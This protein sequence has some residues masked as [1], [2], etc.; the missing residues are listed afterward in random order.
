MNTEAAQVTRTPHWQSP[1]TIPR[2]VTTTPDLRVNVLQLGPSLEVKGGVS[3]VEQ[4]IVDYMAPFASIRHVPTM[5]DGSLIAKSR[6]FAQAITTI[7][8]TLA[9]LEPTVFHI[10]FASRGSTLRKL[11][12]AEMVLRASRPLVMHAHGAKFD[13][14][15]RGLPPPLRRAV[16]RTLQRANVFIALSSQW[17]DFFIEECEL[18]PA[19]VVVLPNPVR[20]PPETVDRVGRKQVQFLFLGR[21][22]QRKGAYDLLNA[23][24]ALP[25]SL[26]ARARLVMAGD[27][28]VEGMRS[29]AAAAN[30]RIEVKS[31]INPRERDRLVAESDVFAL[32]SYAEGMPMALLE[33]MAAGLPAITTPVGGIPDVL[34]HGQEGLMVT[35]GR[36]GELTAAMAKLI[37]DDVGRLDAGRR[38]RERARTYDVSNYA[39]RLAEIYQRI[40][41]VSLARD[42]A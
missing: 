30:D 42:V 34:K 41:P 35:P 3:S 32:P 29:L 6:V 14:F 19:Q 11:I 21:L 23:F 31:W 37:Q 17:R 22:A 7:R 9:T 26:R 18:S 24:L 27:G 28:D 20:V 13:S 5:E 2:L 15:H 10:H 1:N 40:A 8:K 25:E 12:L 39:R 16:N 33:A 36:V 4:L 38:A